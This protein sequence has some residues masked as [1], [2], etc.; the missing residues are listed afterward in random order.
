MKVTLP[1]KGWRAMLLV[2]FLT[3]VPRVRVCWPL[4]AYFKNSDTFQVHSQLYTVC[5]LDIIFAGSYSCILSWLVLFWITRELFPNCKEGV[6]YYLLCVRYE[7]HLAYDFE[8]LSFSV[9]QSCC[10]C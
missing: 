10:C 2:L 1:G 6:L 7:L 3:A 4:S 8:V 9:V 5:L